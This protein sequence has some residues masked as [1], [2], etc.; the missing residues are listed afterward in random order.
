MELQQ[1]RRGQVHL[2]EMVR[3]A[4]ARRPSEESVASIWMP[5]RR[6][7]ITHSQHRFDA[8]KGAIHCVIVVERNYCCLVLDGILRKLLECPSVGVVT[9]CLGDSLD[10]RS[11]QRR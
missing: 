9:E 7:G 5:V 8:P 6:M 2:D 4:S 1:M 3:D 10:K 11:L